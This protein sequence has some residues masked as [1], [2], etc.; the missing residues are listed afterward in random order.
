M[1][2]N[3]E[4]HFFTIYK[5]QDHKSLSVSHTHT[6]TCTQSG[7]IYIWVSS[8]IESLRLLIQDFYTSIVPGELINSM[9]NLF[10]SVFIQSS[11]SFFLYLLLKYFNKMMC[12]EFFFLYHLIL[13]AILCVGVITL[14]HIQYT[15]VDSHKDPFTLDA[16]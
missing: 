1:M 9:L 13:C 11:L 10:F 7:L 16:Q 15:Y 8:I 12:S 14:W 5:L 2:E 6:Q 3:D 4:P